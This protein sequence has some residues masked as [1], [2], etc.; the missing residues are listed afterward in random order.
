MANHTSKIAL[1]LGTVVVLATGYPTQAAT[2]T[3]TD[4]DTGQLIPEAQGAIAISR[5]DRLEGS[6]FSPRDVDLY[7][8][9][10]DEATVQA[11][12]S[13]ESSDLNLFLFDATGRGIK[14]GV[15]ELSLKGAGETV[16]LGVNGMA[17]LNEQEEILLDPTIPDVGSGT[18]GGWSVPDV[19]IQVVIPYTITFEE[20]TE[21]G[22]S[23]TSVP[24]PSSL[25]SI[26]LVVGI[27]CL[28]KKL[29]PNP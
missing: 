18:L 24:E 14:S 5:G 11:S 15:N 12:V 7:Q 28:R 1:V 20:P 25:L 3:E 2:F 8:L 27:V 19:A 13:S 9:Q 22:V 23:S 26:I 17:A 6:L 10:L 21:T 4:F 16:Y 29:T